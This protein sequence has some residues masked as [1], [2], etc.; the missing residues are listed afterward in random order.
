MVRVAPSASIR[1]DSPTLQS[2]RVMLENPVHEDDELL[3]VAEELLPD[4]IIV[5]V[6]I[7]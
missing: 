2:L 5:E 3:E 6:S 1:E 7:I 4:D